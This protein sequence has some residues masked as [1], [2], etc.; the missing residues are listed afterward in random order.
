MWWSLHLSARLDNRI[1][2]QLRR[3]TFQNRYWQL[4][5]SD[6]QVQPTASRWYIPR[7]ACQFANLDS[8]PACHVLQSERHFSAYS[9]QYMALIGSWSFAL[10]EPDYLSSIPV[11]SVP[12]LVD[13]VALHRRL[14]M[15][16]IT[17]RVYSSRLGN[18]PA[19]L[20][21]AS[22][23]PSCHQR[24]WLAGYDW[25]WYLSSDCAAGRALT[26]CDKLTSNRLHAVENSML[27]DWEV[28]CWVFKLRKSLLAYL[29]LGYCSIARRKNAVGLLRSL[30]IYTLHTNLLE[31]SLGYYLALLW[32][33][34]S[35][36]WFR[37][38][39][40]LHLGADTMKLGRLV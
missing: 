11:F 4:F 26:T 3:T 7:K 40:F 23:W 33:L 31:S 25:P 15:I 10:L 34:G 39:R 2:D 8:W 16:T 14:R 27:K 21:M 13:L 36:S 12:R 28:L 37:T 1:K 18:S 24:R 9:A 35:Y 19:A 30:L 32:S 20:Y 6:T 17:S 29:Y 5:H 38:T 22:D